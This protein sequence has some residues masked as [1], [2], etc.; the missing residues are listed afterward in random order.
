MIIYFSKN[1]IIIC[2]LDHGSLN[3]FTQLFSSCHSYSKSYDSLL[4]ATSN[5]NSWS[6]STCAPFIQHTYSSVN[7][8][9]HQN[10]GITSLS[11]LS[12]P[13]YFWHRLSLF[14]SLYLWSCHFLKC[15]L[16]LQ[17]SFW[18]KYLPGTYYV[19][20]PYQVLVSKKSIM[21]ISHQPNKAIESSNSQC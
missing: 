6:S 10:K 5:S 1:R 18:F 12:H 21:R 9:S 15:L 17:C 8:S 11:F 16:H 19:P 13:H 2:L 3:L 14:L 7:L 20:G 4:L